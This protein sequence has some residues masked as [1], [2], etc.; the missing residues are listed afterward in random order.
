MYQYIF[1]LFLSSFFMKNFLPIVFFDNILYSQTS[2]TFL[3]TQLHVLSL[4]SK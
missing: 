4:K 3:P 1:S 2:P